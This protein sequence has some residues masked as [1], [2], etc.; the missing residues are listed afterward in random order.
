MR[1]TGNFQRF[2]DEEATLHVAGAHIL[3]GGVKRGDLF[4]VGGTHAQE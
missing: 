3:S 2:G 1:F 4:A